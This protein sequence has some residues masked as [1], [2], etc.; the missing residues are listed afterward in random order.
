MSILVPS[1]PIAGAP[2][3]APD[4]IRAVKLELLLA[5]LVAQQAAGLIGYW[6][7]FHDGHGVFH[8]AFTTDPMYADLSPE[9]AASRARAVVALGRAIERH[10]SMLESVAPT[11]VAGRRRR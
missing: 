5:G 2:V 3:R 1:T 8:F 11:P 10:H 9:N 4:E 6:A 7:A